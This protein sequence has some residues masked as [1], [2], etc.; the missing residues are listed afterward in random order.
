ML[1]AFTHRD[2]QWVVAQ[3]LDDTIQKHDLGSKDKN[4]CEAVTLNCLAN[5]L[6]IPTIFFYANKIDSYSYPLNDDKQAIV[7]PIIYINGNGYHFESLIDKK[8]ASI[9]KA[10]SNDHRLKRRDKST[11]KKLLSSYCSPKLLLNDLIFDINKR[12]KSRQ[13]LSDE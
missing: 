12:L 7:D 3:A 6:D 4:W 8:R 9:I 11:T 13:D 2:I 10:R 5:L 1:D